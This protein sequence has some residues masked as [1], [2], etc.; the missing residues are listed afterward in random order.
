VQL[1]FSGIETDWESHGTVELF[2][3]KICLGKVEN[4][5]HNRKFHERKQLLE[6]MAKTAI[7]SFK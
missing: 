5:Q 1:D 3:D 7:A 2:H 4:V 6:E